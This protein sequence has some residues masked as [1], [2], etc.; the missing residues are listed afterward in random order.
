MKT[1]KL[2]DEGDL[3]DEIKKLLEEARKT[4]IEKYIKLK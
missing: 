1:C 3:K 2:D 4:P